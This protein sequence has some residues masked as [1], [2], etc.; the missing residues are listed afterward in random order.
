[1][2]QPARFQGHA[3]TLRDFANLRLQLFRCTSR[4]AHSQGDVLRHAQSLEQREVLKHHAY[5]K[6]ARH[7]RVA[8]LQ[9]FTLPANLAAVGLGYAVDDLHQSAFAGTVLAE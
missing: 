1:M 9:R 8:H 2:H 7:G 3:I 5:A 6:A 4:R